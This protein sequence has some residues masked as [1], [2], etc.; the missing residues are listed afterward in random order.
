MKIIN[1]FK[2]F[3]QNEDN[4]RI[5]WYIVSGLKLAVYFL[6]IVIIIGIVSWLTG[7]LEK[8]TIENDLSQSSP[9]FWILIAVLLG[10]MFV[11]AGYGL[12]FSL[13]RYVRPG[14]KGILNH[15]YP[16]GN[17]YKALGHLL[18]GEKGGK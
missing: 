16:N 1:D 9:V 4:K 12:F 10:L 17:S 15:R 8:I 14:G 3:F 13:H 2:H 5:L 11:A 18:D 7:N 6:V